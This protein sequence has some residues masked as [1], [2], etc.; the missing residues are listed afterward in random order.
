MGRNCESRFSRLFYKQEGTPMQENNNEKS[1]LEQGAQLAKDAAAVGKIA[2]QV[3]SGNAV[4]A[5]ITAVQNPDLIKKVVCFLLAWVMLIVCCLCSIP[6][7]IWDAAEQV[8]D[9]LE[10]TVDTMRAAN[11]DAAEAV[12]DSAYFLF[13]G[14][15]DGHEG[16]TG[17]VTA[18]PRVVDSVFEVAKLGWELFT[19][20]EISDESKENLS[21]STKMLVST[22]YGE[23]DDAQEKYYNEAKAGI[24]ME[25]KDI[26]MA[27]KRSATKLRIQGHVK[28][29]RDSINKD[30]KAQM[31]AF[32]ADEYRC[33]VSETNVNDKVADFLLCLYMV[34]TNGDLKSA[35]LAEYDNWLGKSKQ[36]WMETGFFGRDIYEEVPR[37]PSDESYAADETAWIKPIYHW[38]GEFLPQDVYEEYEKLAREALN[39]ESRLDSHFTTNDKYKVRQTVMNGKYTKRTETEL[40]GTNYTYPDFCTD[41]AYT[42][43]Y[44]KVWWNS[45]SGKY[46]NRGAI[47]VAVYPSPRIRYEFKE[48]ERT[49]TNADGE[50]ETYTVTVFYA[51]YE[52]KALGMDAGGGWLDETEEILTDVIRLTD[53][54]LN[55][56]LGEE[57]EGETEP[58]ADVDE[59][60][61]AAD[62][63]IVTAEAP[64]ITRKLSP[65]Q[66]E[67]VIEPN[68]VLRLKDASES[69]SDGAA[70]QSYGKV[71][72]L[73][74]MRGW[75]QDFLRDLL[76]I[77]RTSSSS[78]AGSIGGGGGGSMVEVA[79]GEIG[80]HETGNNDVKY[81]RWMNR[82]GDPWC[83]MFVSWCADQLGYVESG[84][85][86]K[87]A[88]SGDFWDN[89]IGNPDKGTNYTPA[90]VRAGEFTPEA[91]D[92][93]IIS[94]PDNREAPDATTHTPSSW[95]RHVCIVTGYDA[96]SGTIATIDGNSSDQVKEK[97]YDIVNGDGRRLWG[98]VRP[99][100]PDP[101]S[102]YAGGGVEIPG[103]EVYDAWRN[104]LRI[105]TDGSTDPADIGTGYY[106][107]TTSI[108][109]QDGEYIDASKVNYI[110]VPGSYNTSKYLHCLAILK[111][112]ASGKTVNCVIA[113]SG[114]TDKGWGEVSVC[115]GRS[116]GH[117]VNGNC[118]AD[119]NFSVFVYPDCKLTLKANGDQS[120]I[121][122]QI[123][124]QARA[125]ANSHGGFVTES[126]GSGYKP[127]FGAESGGRID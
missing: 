126:G 79:R 35:S 18:L 31:D 30:F 61:A 118:G 1:A 85:F 50:E 55:P 64:S 69:P 109:T 75:Q 116:L 43:D 15:S 29:L 71:S 41:E 86:P 78:P 122:S 39:A 103:G 88:Y 36:T 99:A 121:N 28:D 92:I 90:Q 117:N 77:A 91:G 84:L 102:S 93:L 123:D 21:E 49:R 45:D 105:D 94:A 112:N 6:N 70:I 11:E 113:D 51:Y 38:G 10:E 95:T 54:S 52:I 13:Y 62:T 12:A 37:L 16:L 58:A 108:T 67:T 47:D 111:D 127:N 5:A 74:R 8:R 60:E 87:T 76:L 66:T 59:T 110:V 125:Y 44:S 72:D 3:A 124:A 33:V 9:S 48:E 20:G 57:G 98:F 40:D 115:A 73:E 114:P 22:I 14:T 82:V 7:M 63:D 104:E 119:G 107:A 56:V 68:A 96:E 81:T 80:T 83:A 23:D 120:G 97:T 101:V 106:Q 24:L 26:A 65:F 46:Y 27:N 2:K 19:T 32:S 42:E 89:A 34:Q 17:I 4:G 53:G 100:Y 25:N